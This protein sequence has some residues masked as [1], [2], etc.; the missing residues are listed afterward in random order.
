NFRSFRNFGSLSLKQPDQEIWINSHNQ[1]QYRSDNKYR[2][3]IE[4]HFDIFHIRVGFFEVH[5]YDHSE[6]VEDTYRSVDSRQHQKHHMIVAHHIAKHH[7]LTN[8]T[9]RQRD[10]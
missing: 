5:V 7:E 6:V 4:G 8:K 2:S 1:S 10:T 9:S 3:E